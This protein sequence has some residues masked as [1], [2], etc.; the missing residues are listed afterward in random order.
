MVALF[1]GEHTMIM[2]LWKILV[3]RRSCE[4]QWK[5]D[6]TVEVFDPEHQEKPVYFDKHLN[7]MKC[8]EWKRVRL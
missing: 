6:A 7:C 4:H 5:T 8:G 3:G 2:W 1:A